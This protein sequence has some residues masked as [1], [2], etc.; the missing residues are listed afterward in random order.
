SQSGSTSWA[1]SAITW[2]NSSLEPNGGAMSISTVV[3]P[4]EAASGASCAEGNTTPLVPTTTN[5]SALCT[6]RI[7]SSSAS[8]G[9]CSSKSTTSGRVGAPHSGQ[10]PGTPWSSAR[11]PSPGSSSADQVQRAS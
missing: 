4:C 5:R 8:C 11:G 2:S 9:S 3:A 1:S 7:A 6:S 10:E